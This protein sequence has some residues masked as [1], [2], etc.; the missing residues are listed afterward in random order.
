MKILHII[1]SLRTG[2]A[3]RIVADLCPC[4]QKI[5]D[6]VSVLLLDGTRTSLYDQ[7]EQTG[8][9]LCSL[10]KGW[11]AMRN[12]FLFPRLLRYLKDNAFDI[13]HTHNTFCQ[14][15][16]AA[17][18]VFY[19]LALITT[20]HNT[21]NRRR[22]W[23]WFRP[24][25]RWMYD[26]YKKI[27]CV[28]E[29]TEKAL[30]AHLPGCSGKTAIISNG[31]NLES[32]LRAPADKD[33]LSFDGF[34][35][36][37]VAAFRA[38]KDHATLIQAMEYLPNEY[39][40]FL[41]GGAETREDEKTLQ[42]CQELVKT[43]EL[44]DRVTFLGVRKDVP[45]LLAACDVA[46]LSSHYEGFGLSAVEAMASGKVVIASD[47]ESLTTLVGGAGLLFP[48]GDA[49]AL[50]ALIR[51]VCENPEKAREIGRKCRERAM[52]YDIAETAKRYHALYEDVLA[53]AGAKA[54]AKDHSD[55]G[56][57]TPANPRR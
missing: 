12:P 15:L 36:L 38:Q 8:I 26:K 52:Q 55:A 46:V 54:S 17:A 43:M 6:E 32:F 20:E 14:F 44:E 35:I 1:T 34:K 4:L 37:M 3:E 25:D 16:A 21:S 22:K 40:L 45:Q 9:H 39:R 48:Q 23:N 49:D 28:G 10:S 2:G 42:S 31:I 11:R 33:L 13:V 41:A 19:P 56:P 18:S 50:A 53:K 51:E 7:L 27:V 57:G 24:I 47:V 30:V 29:E 5:G